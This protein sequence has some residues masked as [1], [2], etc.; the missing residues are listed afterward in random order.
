MRHARSLV[1]TNYPP[2]T[3]DNFAYKATQG[4]YIARYDR[5]ECTRSERTRQTC[6]RSIFRCLFNRDATTCNA[7]LL[8]ERADSRREFYFVKLGLIQRH[9]PESVSAKQAYYWAT[10]AFDFRV[11]T[12]WILPLHTQLATGCHPALSTC[13]PQ[14]HRAFAV[15]SGYYNIISIAP[16]SAHTARVTS[17]CVWRAWNNGKLI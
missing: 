5:T 1:R 15:T 7:D 16:V 10:E 6:V 9:F 4:L 14:T 17:R 2:L 11:V 12:R 3:I 13:F 8:N